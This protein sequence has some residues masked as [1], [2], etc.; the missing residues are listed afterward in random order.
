MKKM[1]SLIPVLIMLLSVVSM[2]VAAPI[3]D[4]NTYE[5]QAR[6]IDSWNILYSQQG[7]DLNVLTNLVDGLLTNNADG[8]LIPNA[9]KSY[10]SPD[11]GQT[12]IFTLNEGMTWV[13][14]DG[15]YKAD[16]TS[17]DW[18]TGLEWVLNY[19]KNDA[20]NTSMPKEMIAGATEY[21]EYTKE[22]AET[23]GA[24]AAKALTVDGKF[25]EMVGISAPDPLTVVY[26]CIGKL[27]YFPS[28]ATYNCL[29]PA[30]QGLIDEVGVDGF[31]SITW[32]TMWFSGPYT[33]SSFIFGNEKVL[34][35]NPSYW[36]DANVT[37][38][39]TVTIH[40]VESL[41]VAYQLFQTGELDH[42]TL[43]ESTL[44]TIYENPNHEFH[45]NLV[46]TRPTK[47]S[48]V[49]HL[50]YNKHNEDDSEDTNWNYAVA[51]RNFRLS[52]MYG[53]DW[54]SRL[55]R[56]NAI[57]PLNCEN[58]IYTGNNLCFT[59]DGTDYTQLVRNELGLDYDYSVYN[60]YDPE[61]A[62][63]YKAKAIEELSALGVTF[64]VE[65]EYRYAA[66]DTTKYDDGLVLQQA[67]SDTLGDDYVKIVPRSFIN[68]I[69][70]EVRN[71]RQ[72]SIHFTGW[73]ADY[74]DP[75]NFLNQQTLDDNA[76]F[77]TVWAHYDEVDPENPAY[78]DLAATVQE[79]TDMVNEAH[80]NTTDIDK[81]Y[82]D[83]AKAEAYFL[84]AGLEIPCWYEISWELTCIN[85]FSKVYSMYGIQAYRYVNWE[86]N[87]QIYTTE[88]A[89]AFAGK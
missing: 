12:W 2:A 10:E 89:A 8:D 3:S 61:K 73:G 35:K 86:T 52:L 16:V 15:N 51:N 49:M 60:R 33:V 26:T 42:V 74:A 1:I 64:P 46:E 32:D 59:S 72:Y 78:A 21:Y 47:Y 23:E 53:I 29:Y 31:K 9:A 30:A 77:T 50:N 67:V 43:E 20:T 34:A 28:V 27:P 14:K 68:N 7:Q 40:M 56:V 88:E 39:N 80:A 81:R 44:K 79:F 6:E 66:D 83:F 55:A 11:G 57:N 84:N 24:D 71:T 38:F 58:Y 4:L 62:A 18:L 76:Y 82:A 87:D 70:A 75:I 85:N 45:N 69:T 65:I 37:R 36:N 41:A 13:D 17:A 22:L 19:A 25:A 5:F 54:T 48:W 63:E